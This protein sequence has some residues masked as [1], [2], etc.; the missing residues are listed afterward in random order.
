MIAATPPGGPGVFPPRRDV[1][2]RPAARGHL[3][4][5]TAE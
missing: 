4:R 2:A 3:D 1:A 5:T